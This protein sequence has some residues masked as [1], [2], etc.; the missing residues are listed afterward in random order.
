MCRPLRGCFARAL[1]CRPKSHFARRVE[2]GREGLYLSLR[3]G[4]CCIVYCIVHK[5]ILHKKLYRLFIGVGANNFSRETPAKADDKRRIP[6]FP[7]PDFL[8]SS[9]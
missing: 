5:D 3:G 2:S 7:S 1:G 4:A 6:H 9:F 8:F